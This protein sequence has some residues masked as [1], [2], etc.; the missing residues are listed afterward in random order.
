MVF[1]L[2]TAYRF[3]QSRK[4]GEAYKPGNLFLL[5][6]SIAFAVNDR[7]TL[8]TGEPPSG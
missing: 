5:N 8:T 4:D 7:V 3:N 1:S 2:T 6:P